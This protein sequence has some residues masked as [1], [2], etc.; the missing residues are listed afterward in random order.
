[1]E[2]NE[3]RIGNLLQR[4]NE[5]IEV[6]AI[7]RSN[8][9]CIRFSDRILLGNNHQN[10]FQP[11]ILTEEWLLKFGF[12]KHQNSNEYWDFYQLKNG[13]HISLSKH[14]ELSAGVEIGLCYW[15]DTFIK[16]A[17]VHQLQNLYYALTGEEL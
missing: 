16:V 3:L 6:D 14:N 5:I 17:Y 1:M 8:Y 7:F 4:S 15:G 2:I 11:I 13:W 9:N 10:N 12:K